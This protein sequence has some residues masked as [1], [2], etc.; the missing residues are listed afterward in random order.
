MPINHSKGQRDLGYVGMNGN[1][2]RREWVA[3]VWLG[4]LLLSA[5][6]QTASFDCAK[7]GTKVEHII[8]DNSEISKLDDELAQ[9][10]KSALQDQ[11]QLDAIKQ[12]QKNWIKERNG[13]ADAVC[14]KEAYEARIEIFFASKPIKSASMA[15]MIGDQNA[16]YVIFGQGQGQ[17]FC[18]AI[19]VALNKKK[20]S[21]DYR[22]CMSKEI[23][24]LPGVTDPQWE[25]LDL[26]QHEELAKKIIAINI[27]GTSEYFREQ[28]LSPDMYPTPEGLQRVLDN[29]KKKGGE[30]FTL[31]LSPPLFGD[32][33]LA[34]LRYKDP[35][36]AWPPQTRTWRPTGE[37][38][39]AA[40]VTSDLKEIASGPGLF[41]SRAARPVLYRGK[42]YLVRPYGTNDELEVFV[43][44][45]EVLATVCDIRMSITANT[46]GEE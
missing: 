12:A 42:L 16:K 4:C 25:K 1:I 10:Y 18:E 35:M 46:Q 6:A 21:D 28:K 2:K 41:D 38:S 33:I 27:V 30:L 9:A 15:G 20:I 17:T 36:C 29:A 14:V 26:A 23:L 11:V 37:R 8:C 34:T 40:W 45:R 44:H 24:K 13:C 39:D 32:R 7:A 31:K 3:V 19:L 22:P 43:A 5:P